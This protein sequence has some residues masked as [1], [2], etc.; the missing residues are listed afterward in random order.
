MRMVSPV[1]SL[2]GV[3]KRFVFKRFKNRFFKLCTRAC[4]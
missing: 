1:L 3:T 4:C 2:R